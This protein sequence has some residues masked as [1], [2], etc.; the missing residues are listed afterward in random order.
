MQV[1]GL[2]YIH[3][4]S[5]GYLTKYQILTLKREREKPQFWGTKPF[6]ALLPE[7]G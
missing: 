7:T 3:L 4:H 6:K 2:S 5:E 1:N